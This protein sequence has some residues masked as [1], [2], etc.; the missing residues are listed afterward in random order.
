MDLGDATRNQSGH[1][2]PPEAMHRTGSEISYML[3]LTIIRIMSRS[4]L[5]TEVEKRWRDGEGGGEGGKP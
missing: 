1:L 4:K 2:R 3:A 5:R